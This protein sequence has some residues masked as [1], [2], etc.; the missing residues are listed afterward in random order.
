MS[1]ASQLRRIEQVKQHISENKKTYIACGVTAVV[2]AGGMLLIPRQGS[3]IINA[4][5]NWKPNNVA[6]TMPRKGTLS[7]FVLDVCNG[8][9]VIHQSQND[10]A[11][12]LGLTSSRVSNILNGKSEQFGDHVLSKVA[13][14]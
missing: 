12:A 10:C 9:E 8:I 11:K 7:N 6:I 2:T 5:L 1:K 13:S 3:T 4:G 14:V